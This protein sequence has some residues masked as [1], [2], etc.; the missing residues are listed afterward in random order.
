MHIYTDIV[1]DLFH[2]GHVELLKAARA[3]GTRLTV[4]VCGDDLVDSYKR[5]PIMN[6]QDRNRVIEAC[7]YVDATIPDC[8][9]PITQAFIAEHKIDLVVRG[10]DLSDEARDHWYKVPIE[11]GIYQELPYT[12]GIS[13]TI[14]IER[15]QNR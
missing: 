8:P 15:I 3:M 13:T 2:A 1:G 9:C 6:L 11:M 5:S 10:D 4:G 12:A 7:R 14:I